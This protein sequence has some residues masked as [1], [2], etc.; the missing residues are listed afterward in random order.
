MKGRSTV[1]LLSTCVILAALSAQ[2]TPA[3]P[4]VAF[5]LQDF[6]GVG[7]ALEDVRDRRVVVL[8]FLGVEC[9][10]ARQYAPRLAE[11]A[12]AFEPKGV[13]F[14]GIDSNRQDS[15]SAMG[16]FLKDVATSWPID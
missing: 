9:P 11:L 16:R 13:A 3:E 10:L 15:A 7:H 14:F 8:A 2:G 6:R 12:R 5:R 1:P 4:P